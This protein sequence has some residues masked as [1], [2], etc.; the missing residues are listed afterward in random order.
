MVGLIN[1]QKEQHLYSRQDSNLVGVFG[2]T[3]DPPHIGH[4]ILAEEALYQLSLREVL[5]VLTPNPPHKLHQKITN[6]DIRLKMV[7]AA[8]KSQPR[9]R[10][11]MVD[12]YR[13]PPHFAVDTLKILSAKFPMDQFVYLIGG[14][15][16]HDL[17]TWHLPKDLLRACHSI[18]VLRR[19]DDQ[20]DLDTLENELPGV[21]NKIRWIDTPLI[22]ISASAIRKK[23]HLNQAYRY[24][25]LPPVYKIIQQEMLYQDFQ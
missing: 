13:Q 11:S 10:L 8:L 22:G 15:S 1:A 12:V 18:G 19:P 14:D 9:F 20:V 7:R 24:Y 16:L 4:L 2:G 5:W 6:L 3:F 23:I 25:L 17:P 21:I